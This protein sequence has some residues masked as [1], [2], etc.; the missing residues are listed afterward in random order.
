MPD[1]DSGFSRQLFL[2]WASD[3]KNTV[4]IT[5]RP[6]NGTISHFLYEK[7]QGNF[8]DQ[9]TIDI[10]RSERVPLEGQELIEFQRNQELEKSREIEKLKEENMDFSEEEESEEP[11]NLPSTV[12]SK[13]VLP[14]HFLNSFDYYPSEDGTSFPLYPHKS[15]SWESLEYSPY[16]RVFNAEEFLKNEETLAGDDMVDEETN[17]EKISRVEIPTKIVSTNEQVTK[18]FLFFFFLFF[19]FFFLFFLFFFFFFL[20]Q[21]Q[22]LELIQYTNFPVFLFQ[23]SQSTLFHL[24]QQFFTGKK[25]FFANK[26]KIKRICKKNINK[27][28]H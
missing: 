28:F 23:N 26:K 24:L 4:I 12:P 22:I 25:R 13:S 17:I 15:D 9:N 21:L 3:K 14:N 27:I 2:D 1:L 16:G 19:S 18:I 10:V 5:R 6:T 20:F 7:T 11:Q 8:E